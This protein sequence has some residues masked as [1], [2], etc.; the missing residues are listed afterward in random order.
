M[1]PRRACP[2]HAPAVLA[3]L[4]AACGEPPGSPEAVPTPSAASVAVVPG[5]TLLLE[6]AAVAFT[7]LVRDSTGAPLPSIPVVWSAHPA[8]VL[9]VS[10]DGT[11]RALALGTGSVSAAAGDA[12]DTVTVAV[13]VRFEALSTGAVHTCGVTSVGNAYCWGGNREGRLGTGSRLPAAL[14][15]RVAATGRFSQVSAGWEVS[16]GMVRGVAACWGSNRSGQLGSA[17]K[18]DALAPVRVLQSGDAGFVWVTTLATHS[19]ALAD[20]EHTVW[21]WGAGWA[22]QRGTGALGYGPPEPV[23]GGLD[24]RTVDVGWR[25]SCGVTADGGTW[26]WGTHRDGELGV[27]AAPD[28]CLWADGSWHPC[29]AAPVRVA[30][31]PAFDTIAVGTQHTCG[32]TPEGAAHCWGRNDAGQLGNGSTTPAGPGAVVGAPAFTM[33]SAGDRHTCAL[34]AQGAAWCWGDNTEGALGRATTSGTCGRGPCATSPV[35]VETA[36]RFRTIAASRADGGGHTCGLGTDGYAY[37]WGSNAR[38]QLG[39][40]AGA[41]GGPV[42]RRVAGQ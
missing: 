39:I 38:G 15:Q 36:L 40:G 34:D 32:L 1:P 11:V 5:D 23:A 14:P 30:A 29:A 37:C 21:C 31:A 9:S 7:A 28:S 41:A 33:V 13:R 26:C 27:A 17:S 8:N 10:S 18:D 2:A 16:C 35:P 3:L 42:P 20:G 19:C 25:F 6:G 22:G 4:A 24:F 12:A